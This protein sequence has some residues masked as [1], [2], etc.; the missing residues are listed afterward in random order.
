MTSAGR[1][2]RAR[3]VARGRVRAHSALHVARERRAGVVSM[4]LLSARARSLEEARDA[5]LAAAAA[6][7]AFFA[8]LSHEIRT[9]L[10][11]LLGTA[12]RLKTMGLDDAQR[13]ASCRRLRTRNYPAARRNADGE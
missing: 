4:L 3:D 5:A 8:N 1:A 7:E 13:G 10:H 9:P 6:K 11:G 2:R 12:E